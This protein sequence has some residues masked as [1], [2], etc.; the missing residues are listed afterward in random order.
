MR[1]IVRWMVAKRIGWTTL[2]FLAAGSLALGAGLIVGIGDNPPGLV[3]CY[4]AATAFL[5]AFAHNWRKVKSFLLLLGASLVGLPLFA[6]L[7]NLFYALGVLASGLAV[8]GP[9]LVVLEIASFV[10]AIFFWPP[11]IL[12]GALGAAALAIS[13]TRGKRAL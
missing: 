6:I 10:V 11:G 12:V 8:V 1:R 2:A 4:I 13:H 9:V 7:H 3:L 5:L